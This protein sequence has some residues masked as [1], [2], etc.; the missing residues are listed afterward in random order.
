MN[1]T[2]FITTATIK[3]ERR[4]EGRI[5]SFNISLYSVDASREERNKRVFE[6]ADEQINRLCQ[7]WGY[8]VKTTIHVKETLVE[9]FEILKG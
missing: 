2:R 7:E 8:R 4:G 9:N 6:M 1:T 5:Y 3:A